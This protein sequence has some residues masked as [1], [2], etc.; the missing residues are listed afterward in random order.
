MRI[1]IREAG[2]L[3]CI[4]FLLEQGMS[5]RIRVS[6]RSMRP[7]LQGNELVEIVPI[8]RKKIKIGDILLCCDKHGNPLLH[9][10]HRRYYKDNVLFFQT[11]GDSCARFDPAIPAHQVLGCVWHIV[12]GEQK[13]INLQC[14]VERVRS[15]FFVWYTL[16]FFALRQQRT[17]FRKL[18][19][20]FIP[21]L[22]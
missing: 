2:A 18:L 16:V 7:L 22:G 5:V 1:G 15:R 12:R 17:P 4:R 13:N 9:R 6:G 19:C 10:L 11:R 14:P 21:P 3:D 8:T 20:S